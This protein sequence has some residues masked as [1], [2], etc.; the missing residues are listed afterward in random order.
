MLQ[1]AETALACIY[2]KRSGHKIAKPVSY[3]TQTIQIFMV[4]LI[5]HGVF[6]NKHYYHLNY[7]DICIVHCREVMGRRWMSGDTKDKTSLVLSVLRYCNSNSLFD[8]F[9]PSVDLQEFKKKWKS[10]SYHRVFIILQILGALLHI[11][12][13]KLWRENE[14]T[15]TNEAAAEGSLR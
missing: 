7:E 4:N 1:A 14:P 11:S 13:H 6:E 10:I 9:A 8:P 12:K 3:E 5:C 15:N 2:L